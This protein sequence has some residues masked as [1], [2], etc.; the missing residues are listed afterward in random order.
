MGWSESRARGRQ[1]RRPMRGCWR[2]HVGGGRSGEFRRNVRGR[3]RRHGRRA[4]RR[5]MAGDGRR[6]IRRSYCREVRRRESGASGR[7]VGGQ[8]RGSWSGV[9]RWDRETAERKLKT[10]LVSV[11]KAFHVHPIGPDV[12]NLVRQNRTIEV[13]ALVGQNLGRGPRRAIAEHGHFGVNL[14]VG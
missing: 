7:F 13:A 12:V 3:R 4:R 6:H 9:S 5:K 11:S 8:M 1:G 10:A 2:G 14:R